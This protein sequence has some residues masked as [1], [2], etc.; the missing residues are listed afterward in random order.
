MNI[1]I[2]G[3]PHQMIYHFSMFQGG[4]ELENFPMGKNKYNDMVNTMKLM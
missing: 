1:F 3:T 2:L 4:M